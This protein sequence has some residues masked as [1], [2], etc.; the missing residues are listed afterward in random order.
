MLIG[1]IY[2]IGL[3]LNFIGYFEFYFSDED[4][5]MYE[6]LSCYMLL[7]PYTVFILMIVIKLIE[8]YKE[9]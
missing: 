3:L 4:Y 8:K 2:F 5:T 9:N 6:I 1:I 7:L